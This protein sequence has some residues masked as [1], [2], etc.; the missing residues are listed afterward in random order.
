MQRPLPRPVCP[1]SS[2]K[3]TA[4]SIRPSPWSMLWSRVLADGQRWHR[5][6]AASPASVLEASQREAELAQFRACLG[7]V[8]LAVG[9]R[10]AQHIEVKT[11]P[12][13]DR[14]PDS[15]IEDRFGAV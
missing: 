14:G 12:A 6:C 2:C 1:P 10:L 3:R 4:I 7:V 9:A 5:S 13:F 8:G 15:E 11:A